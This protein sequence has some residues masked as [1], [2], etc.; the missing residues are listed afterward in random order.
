MPHNHVFVK[1]EHWGEAPVNLLRI[2]N[3]DDELRF[4]VLDSSIVFNNAPS[5]LKSIEHAL[6]SYPSSSIIIDIS[7]V[8]VIDSSAIGMF[9]SVKGL[10]ERQKRS[11]ALAGV[12]DTICRILAFLEVD[13]YFLGHLH[14]RQA[15]SLPA[16]G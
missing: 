7:G 2:A 8:E 4:V 5:L 16:A 14:C 1:I 15:S 11:F 12:S 3:Q 6:S 10:A 9:I 13:D